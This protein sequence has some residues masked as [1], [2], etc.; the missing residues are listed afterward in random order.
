MKPS[1]VEEALLKITSDDA[2]R[3][4][5]ILTKIY[6][7][8]HHVDANGNSLYHFIISGDVPAANKMLAIKILVDNHVNTN[9]KNRNGD[10]FLHL[11][12]RYVHDFNAISYII[13]YACTKGFF[14]IN[15]RNNCYYT[16]LH[17]AIIS[18]GTQ[19]ELLKTITILKERGFVYSDTIDSYVES[20]NL[21]MMM[22]NSIRMNFG[23]GKVAPGI[24]PMPVS[25]RR[26]NPRVNNPFKAPNSRYGIVLN[27]NNYQTNPAIGRES[28]IED[29]ITSLSTMTKLP[30][31]V[32][33]SGV[34]KT[35]IADGIAYNI[36][37]NNV[38]DFM[39]NR[40]ICEVH[41]FDVTAGTKYRGDMEKVA[42]ELFKYAINNNMILFIDE[43]HMI[44]GAGASEYDHTDVSD[45]LRFYIDRYNLK[46]IGATTTEEYAQYIAEHPLK[47]RFDV[48]A[49]N[50]L[51]NFKLH[52]VA[53]AAID[54]FTA[55]Q[56]VSYN[57]E[58]A[59]KID[60]I[61]DTL[62][63]L[64]SAEHRVQNDQ[65]YN[66]D[67]IIGLIDRAVAYASIKPE[68]MLEIEHFIKS[69]Q[70]AERLYGWARNAAIRK[71]NMLSQN[72]ISEDENR[73]IDLNTYRK[74]LITR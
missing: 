34:G 30:I 16:I 50:E 40:P 68:H 49:V 46:V 54:K 38:P 4:Q 48:I 19:E 27:N 2:S 13:N 45:I 36:V 35:T 10:T 29:T 69:I 39:L 12:F 55:I 1:V 25:G 26:E 6:G 32:G 62:L 67:L 23:Y 59:S 33:H 73:I 60:D 31:L 21:S 41:A 22:K 17:S 65:V 57:E 5:K 51:D 18:L 63:E 74:Q 7:D 61:V 66:P 53:I 24:P 44:F 9:T 11:I 20:S 71:L 42:R 37:H 47:R 52:D 64:T 72:E 58:F 3:N 70:K 14:D 28:E 43:F 8:L 56:G 15:A